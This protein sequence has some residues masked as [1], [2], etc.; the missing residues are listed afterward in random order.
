M[1]IT[2]KLRDKITII[3]ELEKR[4]FGA[5]DSFKESLELTRDKKIAYKELEGLL[6]NVGQKFGELE[7]SK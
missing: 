7:V 1:K 2:E 3:I 4:S 5:F 6:L